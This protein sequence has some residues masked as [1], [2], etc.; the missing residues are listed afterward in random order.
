MPEFDI[1]YP[2]GR[3]QRIVTEGFRTIRNRITA[4]EL[5]RE[6]YDGAR[7][8]GYGGYNYDGRWKQIIQVLVQRYGLTSSSRILDV[9]CKKGFFLHDLKELLPGISVRGVENHLYPLENCMQSVRAD[10]ELTDYQALPFL[11]DSFDFVMAFASIYMLNL[12]DVMAAIRE[13]QRVGKGKSYIT[14]G[15][16]RTAEER[17][18]FHDWTVL[19]TT[20]LH[21]DDWPEV[22]RH[23]GYTG[24][25]YFTTASTLHLVRP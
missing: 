12:R 16:Y 25:Y 9:G 24:D 22:F 8:N 23:C 21:V 19:G 3:V 4:F 18:L 1:G 6:Y 2:H 17:D 15:A 13:I 7:E 5:D 10:V 14:V 20:V 11:D